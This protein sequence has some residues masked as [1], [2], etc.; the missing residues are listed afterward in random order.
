MQAAFD[1][2][3]SHGKVVQGLHCRHHTFTVFNEEVIIE[4]PS[5]VDDS[6]VY[7]CFNYVWCTMREIS[8]SMFSV[9]AAFAFHSATPQTLICSLARQSLL[10]AR[11]HRDQYNVQFPPATT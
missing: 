7:C 6:N 1:Q 8:R 11:H 10:K 9:D 3:P 2:E 4:R 5:F